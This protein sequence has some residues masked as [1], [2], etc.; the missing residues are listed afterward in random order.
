MKLSTTLYT[1]YMLDSTDVA[2]IMNDKEH[3]KE[4]VSKDPDETEEI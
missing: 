2:I 3:F 1:V 4:V